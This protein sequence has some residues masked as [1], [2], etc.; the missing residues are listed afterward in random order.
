M[1]RNLK[2]IGTFKNSASG[3]EMNWRQTGDRRSQRCTVI[4]KLGWGRSQRFGMKEAK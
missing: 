4:E 1:P 2:E 3:A